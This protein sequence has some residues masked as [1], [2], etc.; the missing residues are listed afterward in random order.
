[1]TTN[2]SIEKKGKDLVIVIKNASEADFG[3]SKSGKSV[4]IASTL[5]NADISAVLG[6]PGARLGLNV[7][8]PAPN[9]S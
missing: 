3:R 7:Y 9:Q 2:V 8:A 5:G 6:R 1:M 4:T